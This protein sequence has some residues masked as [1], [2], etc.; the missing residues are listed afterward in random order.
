MYAAISAKSIASTDNTRQVIVVY[1][2]F[3]FPAAAAVQCARRPRRVITVRFSRNS[4]RK[5]RGVS[6]GLFPPARPYQPIPSIR[7]RK[8]LGCLGRAR[9]FFFFLASVLYN[10]ISILS[11]PH[12]F[13]RK[14][15]KTHET[16]KYPFVLLFPAVNDESVHVRRLRRRHVSFPF[17]P[18]SYRAQ[19][20]R[21]H[22]RTQYAPRGR[23]TSVNRN[24]PCRFRAIIFFAFGE[25]SVKNT[26]NNV[27]TCSDGNPKKNISS[28]PRTV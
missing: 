6:P 15:R 13:V 4:A 9:F 16:I 8:V 21:P 2:Y 11:P 24:I 22:E 5:F 17:L 18:T 7:I 20:T 27:T 26:G 23:P 10:S 25:A 3:F 28:R 19:T 12:P 14:K 1:I